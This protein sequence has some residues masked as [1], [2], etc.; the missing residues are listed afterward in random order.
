VD[1]LRASGLSHVDPFA[2]KKN[3]EP[4]HAR[5]AET[6]DPHAKADLASFRAGL[7]SRRAN[8]RDH[9]SDNAAAAEH[10]RAARFH[11]AAMYRHAALGNKDQALDHFNQMMGHHMNRSFLAKRQARADE[12]VSSRDENPRART[13]RSAVGSAK[14]SPGLYRQF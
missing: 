3:S 14:Q 12:P 8:E 4:A 1:D 11:A 6:F 10:E 9:G 13:G 7:V 2:A 5:R